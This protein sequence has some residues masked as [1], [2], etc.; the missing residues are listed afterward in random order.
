MIISSDQHRQ[1]VSDNYLCVF[2]F[3]MHF[4]SVYAK[5]VCFF[6]PI[7]PVERLILYHWHLNADPYQYLIAYFVEVVV[8]VFQ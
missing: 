2:L 8:Y 6:H 3:I 5:C 4:C 7:I 1:Y